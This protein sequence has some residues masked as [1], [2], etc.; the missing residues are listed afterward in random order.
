MSNQVKNAIDGGL[1]GLQ[2]TEW[3]VREILSRARNDEAAAKAPRR[4]MGL[5]AALAMVLVLLVAGVT[6]RL[7][8]LG[9]APGDQVLTP[10]NSGVTGPGGMTQQQ[11]EEAIAAAETHVY[12][13][14]DAQAALRAGERY[15]ITCERVTRLAVKGETLT[16]LYEVSFR[17]RNVFDTEYTVWLSAADGQVLH[18]QE[19][20]GAA[21]G[22]TA[23]EIYAG[24]ARVYGPD[25]RLWSQ[26]E[27]TTYI[28]MLFRAR[29]DSMRWIDRLY[30]LSTYPAVAE[31][32]MPKEEAIALVQAQLP[33]LL[34]RCDEEADC[35]GEWTST[36]VT[37]EPRA[38]YIGGQQ[39]NIWKVAL[40]ATAVS[41]DGYVQHQTILTEIDSVTGEVLHVQ[42]VDAL[43]GEQYESFRSDVVDTL[44]TADTEGCEVT[45][46]T[47]EQNRAVAAE[48]I[49]QTWG[50]TRD[51]NDEMLFVH[52]TAD[53]VA[54]IYQ[55]NVVLVYTSLGE[56]DR[57]QYA[58]AVDWYGE[59]IAANAAT[60]P[61]GDA[62]EAFTP[63]APVLDWKWDNLIYWQQQ[64]AASAQAE[65]PIVQL[66]INSTY[67]M[68]SRG[69]V[70]EEAEQA[71]VNAVG[72][73]TMGRVVSVKFAREPHA[74]WKIAMQTDRGDCLVEVED[75]TWTVIDVTYVP[76]MYASWY[77][78]FILTEDLAAAGLEAETAAVT[79]PEMHYTVCGMRASHLYERFQ[80]V[81]GPDVGQWTQSQLRE[82]QQMLMVSG[83][84]EDDLA[85]ACIRK[86]V[87]PDVPDNALT[88]EEAAQ[89]AA[90]G[91]ALKDN[92]EL[93]GCVLIGTESTPVW[94]VC[95]RVTG[96]EN[97][98]FWF[99]EVNCITGEVVNLAVNGSRPANPSA[100]Y[101]D[102]TPESLWFRDIV[103]EDTIFECDEGWECM[104]NG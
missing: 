63:T 48:Y 54:P 55:C 58:V 27:L 94:K 81:Y 24:F 5:Y 93:A 8:Q 65:D 49:R 75:E 74:V 19:Q 10:L 34:Q 4:Q 25:R 30:E 57:V 32:A 73:R 1:R 56:G 91:V 2:V 62:R 40:D 86:T 104:G 52:A 97:V 71:A 59:V 103:L 28:T 36:D 77:L 80:K 6:L 61:A 47:A 33:A 83:E 79:I 84:Y 95:L 44:M 21:E 15:E 85:V 102:G 66:F 90:Q 9:A 35:T 46:R 42:R 89:M 23:Q 100:T 99:V 45:D 17:P 29:N 96:G 92:W 50:E 70:S 11:K 26:E 51:V 98:A 68:D 87:Y 69:G 53:V 41:R 20:R 12:E 72:C 67:E 78:P 7:V 82:F 38:R 22:H 60:V 76:S 3:S 18:C 13:H 88:R 64:A 16:N 37:G 43:Y 14:H 39:S 101:D 31:D